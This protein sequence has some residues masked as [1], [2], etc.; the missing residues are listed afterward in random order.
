MLTKKFWQGTAE[1]AISTAA[2]TAVALIGADVTGIIDTAGMDWAGIAATV[3]IAAVLSVLKSLAAGAR[4]G[5]PSVGSVEVPKDRV[6][7]VPPAPP[8]PAEEIPRERD[9]LGG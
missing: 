7:A 4:D 2:Q 5:S 6:A 8:V 1:R 9:Q 3:G